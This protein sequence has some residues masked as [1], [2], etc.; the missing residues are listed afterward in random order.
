[1]PASVGVAAVNNA[2]VQAGCRLACAA[3]SFSNLKAT[4]SA[5]WMSAAMPAGVCVAVHKLEAQL[6]CMASSSPPPPPLLCMQESGSPRLLA[7]MVQAEALQAAEQG[8]QQAAQRQHAASQHQSG[9]AA[10]V[11]GGFLP[12]LLTCMPHGVLV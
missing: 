2:M 7:L 10:E 9:P 1:M 8:L 11:K 5:A 6:G 4:S 12:A 3:V